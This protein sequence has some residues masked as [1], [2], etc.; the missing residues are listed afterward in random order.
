M[1][2]RIQ[3]SE[4][5]VVGNR[6]PRGLTYAKRELVNPGRVLTTTVRTCFSDFPLLPVRTQGEISLES[7]FAIMQVVNSVVVMKRL[8]PGDIVLERL[9]GTQIALIA[10]DDMTARGQ[11]AQRTPPTASS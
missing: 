4:I 3:G 10:T 6:C 8:Q 11:Q 7:I 2:A 9:P 1:E 5:E